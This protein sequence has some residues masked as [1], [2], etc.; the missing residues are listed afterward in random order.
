M[1]D[2]LSA[3]VEPQL[4]EA[5][6][7]RAKVEDRSVSAVIRRILSAHVNDERRPHQSAAVKDRRGDRR[8]AT[9]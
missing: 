8:D 3:A 1:S 7:A 6:R 2:Y 4:A 5:I 9:G